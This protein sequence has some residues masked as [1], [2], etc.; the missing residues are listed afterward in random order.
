MLPRAVQHRRPSQLPLQRKISYLTRST[1]RRLLHK[2]KS[3]TTQYRA[4][5]ID[6]IWF[7]SLPQKI[8]QRQFTREEQVLLAGNR[9]MVNLDAADEALYRLGR[10]P[11]TSVGTLRSDSTFHSG[12]NNSNMTDSPSEPAYRSAA[13]M[14]DSFYDTFR[15][16]DEDDDLDLTLD[17]YHNAVTETTRTPLTGGGGL[18]ALRRALSLTSLQPRRSSIGPRPP[19]S[20]HSTVA[21][22]SFGLGVR[23]LSSLLAPRHQRQLSVSSIEPLAKHYQDPEARLKLRLYLASPQKFDEAIEFGFPSLDSTTIMQPPA[24]AASGRRADETERTF[25]DDDASPQDE[26]EEKDE[27]DMSLAESDSPRTPQDTM[28]PYSRPSKK[29]SLDRSGPLRPHILGSSPDPFGQSAPFGREMTLHMTLTRPDLRT[30][31]EVR[32][33]PAKNADPLKL[34]DLPI[35]DERHPIWDSVPED[36]SKV[37]KFWKKLT[38]R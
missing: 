13:N 19:Q 5:Q 14:H 8:Q 23:P 12:Q 11:N 28:F 22:P 16:L 27:E 34:S 18:P 6:A 26:E 21:P 4:S 17:D 32:V 20:S 37:K 2:S 7:S 30:D 33:A 3:I 1:S 36:G 25:L 15:W 24:T 31:T 9:N 10:Q 35:S 38:S 29:N